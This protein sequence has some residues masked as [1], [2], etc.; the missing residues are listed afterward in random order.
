MTQANKNRLSFTEASELKVSNHTAEW[1]KV[2]K[3]IQEMWG[4]IYELIEE[5]VGE[6]QVDEIF[7]REYEEKLHALLDATMEGIK[8]SI[9]RSM[10]EYP[11]SGLI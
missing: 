3:D 1:V 9:W 11:E 5:E 2:Y 10:G 7:G 8:E 4:T 6:S